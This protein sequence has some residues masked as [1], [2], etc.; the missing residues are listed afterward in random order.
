MGRKPL[1]VLLCML[2]Y[3][4]AS[5]Q[6]K[7]V[8][9]GIKDI[10]GKPV[11]QAT[12]TVKHS[13]GKVA[14]DK[15]GNFRINAASGDTLVVTHASFIS[16]E[17]LAG[18]GPLNIILQLNDKKLD[19]VV[20]VGY[21][22]QSRAKVTGAVSVV[23]FDKT[24]ENRPIT[25]ASQALSGKV[26]GLWV[27]QNSGK[28]GDDG[29]QL[30]VRG[31]GTLNNSDPLILIDG[32]EGRMSQVN[33][34]DIESMSILKDA[35]SAA[36]YGSKAA[37][38]VIL[39]TTKSGN[40]N[41]GATISINSYAGVQQLGRRFD[42]ISNSADYMGLWNRA[43]NN[44]G[45]SDLFPKSVIDAFRNNNDAFVYPN[46][47]FFDELYRTAFI[48]ENTV[49][50]RGGS[51][52]T[53]FYLSANYLDQDGILIN[54][55][56][57]RYGLT[58]NVESKVKT[59][60]TLGGRINGLRR[61]SGEPFN[62]GR[63]GYIFSNGGYPFTAPYTANGSYGAPQALLNGNPI[64]GN[65][66]PLIE[67]ANGRTTATNDYMRMNAYA[68]I[69]FTKNLKLM[70]NFSS[71]VENVIT[72]KNNQVIY[73]YT[74]EGKPF[75]NLDYPT[76]L[77]ASRNNL[78]NFFYTWYNSLN[79]NKT[80]GDKH[81]I[82]VI[83]G[84]QVENTLIKNSFARSS[85]PPKE[86]LTQID[87]GTTGYRAQ[88]NFQSLHMLSYFG[89]INYYFD[90]KYLFEANLRADASSR[91]MK[92]NRWGYFPSFSVGWKI[93]QEN[94]MKDQKLFSDLK[95][96]AS[97]G[98]LGNQNIN[99]YWPYIVAI[100]QNNAQ[101]YNFGGQ[102]SPGASITSLIDENITWE[103]TASTNL[104]LDMAFLN[105]QL[106][107]QADY[108]VKN[109]SDIIVQLPIPQILG[110]VAAPFENVGKMKNN[111]VE[112][113]LAY[114]KPGGG[115][116]FG[117]KIGGNVTYTKNKV[118]KFR[119]N[120][121]DQL[122]LIREGYSFQT[123]YGFKSIGVYQSNAEGA[124]HMYANGY[125][126]KAGELKF[127]DVNGDGKLDFNDRMELGN[128]IPKFTYGINLDLNY[129]GFDLSVLLQGIAGVNGYTQSAWTQPLGI[130]GGIITN[131][132]K[133]SWTPEN[134]SNTLPAI[135]INNT[136]NNNQSSFWVS[137]LAFV[138]MRNVQLGYSVPTSLSSKLGLQKL[139]FYLNGQNL[140]TIADKNYE[141]FDPERNT[142]DSG[143]GQYPL[144]RIV[145]FGLNVTL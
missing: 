117:Y 130:S 129:K 113:S 6:T 68:N 126:P 84:T 105:N 93:T 94:F 23:K 59:W 121:P 34:N 140:F 64:V 112:F 38:G 85:N 69:S 16:K 56:S 44:A 119:D 111:G 52:K 10:A 63:I 67:T 12:I 81:E 106:T 11:S 50:V 14:S 17:V 90:N 32:I 39:I 45:G 101:S 58:V 9:G 73:G 97:W 43:L 135:Q 95:V 102:F 99:N 127:E 92:G 35:A 128:T 2:M 33:P 29:A 54:T 15:D 3:I 57:K 47:N 30:R 139:Y 27:S 89:R 143:A 137:S 75:L 138:K 41:D 31:W 96:R 120:A 24:L 124:Q 37:N 104:G 123:L 109:T 87:A 107:V 51:E 110:G 20:V 114:Q 49:S 118:V 1:M 98:K 77:E 91:F 83:A 80:F 19:E 74:N 132:W 61:V 13:A 145:S 26:T 115:D 72:D 7:E 53:K 131:R 28:P 55:D 60:L 21:G 78:N 79:Y 82:A 42:I 48:Q 40:F 141:G 122:Y 66:N 76:Q 5:A 133:D 46:T 136:W 88:C 125:V 65:R 8:I 86:G 36:I 71:Q 116:K 18:T 62:L 70:S 103:S 25:N 100:T 134:R 4:H 22:T 142:F 108:F 144:P